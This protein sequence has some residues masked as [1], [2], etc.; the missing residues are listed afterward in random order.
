MRSMHVIRCVQKQNR[1]DYIGLL[2]VLACDSLQSNL[3]RFNCIKVL[4]NIDAARLAFSRLSL[5]Y[6]YFE[7]TGQLYQ[8]II[9][10]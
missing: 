7:P 2:W 3:A 1:I 10:S 4:C 5:V 8:F 9:L 6:A